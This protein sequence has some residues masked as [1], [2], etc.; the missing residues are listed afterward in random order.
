M[1]GNNKLLAENDSMPPMLQRL[2]DLQLPLAVTLGRTSLPI[3]EVLKLTSGSIVELDRYAGEYL[4]LTIH[5][6]V[7]ARGEIV[8]VKGNYG[9]RIKELISPQDRMALPTAA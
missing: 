2:M 3:H 5:G 8:S 6:T 4:D 7:V 1:S 9:V